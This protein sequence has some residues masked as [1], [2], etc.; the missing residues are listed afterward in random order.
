MAVRGAPAWRRVCCN[1]P[2]LALLCFVLITA[3]PASATTPAAADRLLTPI[4]VHSMLYLNTPYSAMQAMFKEAAA[5]GASEIRLDLELSGVF[6]NPNS[7]PDWSGVDQYMSLAR[8]YRLR[9]LA[10]LTATPWYMADCPIATP[11]GSP[12]W[13]CPPSDPGLWGREAGE[14]AAYTR[15]VIN[16]FEIINEP[17]GSWAFLGT[18]QQYALVLA[19][20]YDAIHAANP[21]AR[22]ALGGLMNIG[23][24]GVT[25]MNAMLATRGADARHKF[26]IA[27]IHIRTPNP[28]TTGAV[29]R[30]WRHY[31]SHNGFDG[32]LWVTE[33]GYPANPV[34]QTQPGYQD[35]PNAQARWMTT[36]IPAMVKAG[37]AI[38]VA[39]ERDTKT[40]RYASE[41]V[42]QSTDPLTADLRYA[43]RPS[44][45]AVR[46]IAHR[47]PDRT[48][49]ARRAALPPSSSVGPARTARLGPGAR[50]CRLSRRSCGGMGLLATLAAETGHQLGVT[51]RGRP[52][53]PATHR[54][55]PSGRRS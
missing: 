16:D 20:A 39:T 11:P 18:P 4:G 19:S 45:Y 2:L 47:R 29:V 14:I 53:S 33:T 22:V 25:W 13:I 1:F 36:A 26:D 48:H 31:F 51:S 37:A 42:L 49:D 43:R 7:P 27:N 46:A 40:G 38:V 21:H 35:G 28:A 30:S 52:P 17:D 24:D 12:S 44:F 9:V 10:D 5:I 23:A 32:P 15:G 54:P 50:G 3:A 8:R 55:D 6:A 41:G 34:F